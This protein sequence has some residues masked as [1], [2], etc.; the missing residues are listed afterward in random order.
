MSSQMLSIS[1]TIEGKFCNLS[2]IYAKCNYIDRWALQIDLL[3]V[4]PVQTPWFAA[5]DLNTICSQSK[6]LGGFKRYE[7]DTK[8]F[9]NFIQ[10]ARLSEIPFKFS[11]YMWF[12][13]TKDVLQWERLDGALCNSD[14]LIIF[15]DWK[16]THLEKNVSGHN[17]FLF[18]KSLKSK[19]GPSS[20]K[21]QIMW[22]TCPNLF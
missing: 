19:L 22:L 1:M 20:F 15:G 8:D 9:N 16:F 4:A 5:G 2:F 6:T 7:N 11:K 18:T 17:P 12:R 21:F 13:K 10:A 14:W 3:G